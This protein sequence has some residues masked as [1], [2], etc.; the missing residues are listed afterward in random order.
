[1]ARWV[2]RVTRWVDAWLMFPRYSIGVSVG[3]WVDAWL[4][5]LTRAVD[6]LTRADDELTRA[7][8]VSESL[9]VMK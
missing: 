7:D 2:F 3:R 8:D 6:G 4:D 1:M 9:E 5:G